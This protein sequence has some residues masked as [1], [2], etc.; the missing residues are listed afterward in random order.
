MARVLGA[1]GEAAVS[2][3]LRVRALRP[4]TDRPGSQW[5]AWESGV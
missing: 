4:V 5:G 3:P 2:P 1:K